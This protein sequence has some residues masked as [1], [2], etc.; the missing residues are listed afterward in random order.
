MTRFLRNGLAIALVCMT[1]VAVPHAKARGPHAKAR[2][3]QDMQITPFVDCVSFNQA[4]NELSVNF[5]YINAFSESQFIDVGDNNFI[6]PAPADRD[7]TTLFTAGVVHD[8]WSVTILLNQTPSITWSV[9]GV[10]ATASNDPT[11]YCSSCQCPAGPIGPT[12]NQGTQG[13]TGVQ[14]ATGPQG[15]TGPQGTTGAQGPTGTQGP[16]GPQGLTGPQGT[17]GA[18]GPTGQQGAQGTQGPTGPQGLMGPQGL[19]GAAGPQGP[20]GATGPQ[21]AAGNNNVFPSAQEYEFPGIAVITI[22]DAHVLATSM[23]LVQYVG[24]TGVG[25]AA[26]VVTYVQNGQFTVTGTAGRKFRYVVFN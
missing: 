5:G 26:T 14:G 21:G 4:L 20:Q 12:G 24:A 10:S 15:L 7:Q 3:G 22:S 23:I 13:T 2:S 17:T 18:Q 25:G 16:A 11:T 9:T 19:T 6:S 1:I 8:A